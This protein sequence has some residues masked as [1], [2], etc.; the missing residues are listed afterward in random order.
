MSVDRQVSLAMKQAPQNAGP[1]NSHML[2]LRSLEMMQA[3]SP[4][5]MSRMVSYVDT[6]LSLNPGEVI[7][8]LKRKKAPP[9][10]AAKPTKALKK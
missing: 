2:V 9:A 3:I 6:L 4:D 1:I 5:Y 10:K 7:V 8:P